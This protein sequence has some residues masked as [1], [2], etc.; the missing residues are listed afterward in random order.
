MWRSFSRLNIPYMDRIHV[1]A[2]LATSHRSLDRG[3]CVKTNPTFPQRKCT[4]NMFSEMLWVLP[5]QL[6]VPDVMRATCCLTWFAMGETTESE[7]KKV[8]CP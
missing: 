3:R 8:V 2:I 4:G 5:G 7:Y 1:K 6:I